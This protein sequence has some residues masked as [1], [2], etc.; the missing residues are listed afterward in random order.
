[1]NLAG[2][3]LYGELNRDWGN[4]RS[5]VSLN[6]TTNKFDGGVPESWKEGL[7]RLQY[8]GLCDNRLNSQGAANQNIFRG[9]LTVSFK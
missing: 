4:I 8:A 1:M 5:L 3:S 7:Q 9:S 6:L 2:N